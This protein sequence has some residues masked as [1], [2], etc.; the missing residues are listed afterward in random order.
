MKKTL[1]MWAFVLLSISTVFAQSKQITGTV[2]SS[3]DGSGLPGVNITIV[4]TSQGA[5]TDID[6]KYQLN[7][8]AGQVLQFSFVGFETQSVTVGNQSTINVTLKVDASE[9]A[10]VVVTGAYGL[11]QTARSTV[12]NTQVVDQKTLNVIRQ[13]DINNALAGKVSGIQ[14]R[15]QSSAALGRNT[16]V[17]L[18]GV[19]GFGVGTGALYVV[20]GTILPNPGNLNLDDIESVT[21][22]QGAA[23]AAQFGSQGANGAIVITLKKGSREKGIGL[24]VN[25][26][27]MAEKAYILPNY[28]NAYAGGSFGDLVQF[29][30]KAG[31]PEEW[32]ALDG[33]Y[34]HDYSDDSSWGPRMVGQEYIPWYSWYPGHKY[35]G[36]TA[37]LLPQPD[38]AREFFNTGVTYNNTFTVSAGDE[39]YDLKLSYGNQN[40]TGVIPSTSLDKH[41]LN[42]R[43]SYSLTDKLE[44]SADINYVSQIQKGEIDDG[45]ANNS[46][47]SFSQ[48]FHRNV[49]MGIMKELAGVKDPDGLTY[50]TW[51]H[52]NPD[53][54]NPSNPKAFYAANYWYNFYTYFN[55][56]IRKS[57]ADRLYGNLAATYKVNDA[58]SLRATY[59]KN[60]VI[61]SNDTRITTDLEESGL[62]TGVRGFYGYGQSNSNRT[63]IEFLASY[64]KQIGDFSIN[65]SAGTDFFTWEFTS[66]GANTNQG[67][68]VANL[69][70]IT[71][72]VDPAT[73]S[74]NR[75]LEKYR[76]VIGRG[77]FGW[78]DLLYADVTLRNDWYST[79]PQTNN[80]VLSKS[81]GGSFVFY[82]LLKDKISW[83]SNGK[84]RASWGEIPKALGTSN[85][86]FG[87]YRFPGAAYSVGN[88]KWG[89]YFTMATA[90]TLVDPNIQGSTVTQFEYGIDAQFLNDRIG[91]SL[92]LWDGSEKN[93]PYSL[94]VNGASGYTSLLTNIGLIE[95]RGI[96]LQVNGRPILTPNLSWRITGTYSKLTKNDIIELSKEFGI[97]QTSGVQ[98]VWGTTM[99]YLVH[100]E[101]KRWGQIYGNGIKRIN[102]VPVLNSDG[103]YVNQPDV[104]FGSV[105]P[106]FTGGLQNQFVI[107]K[108]FTLNVNID[109]QVGG[110]FVS[111]SNQWGSF[112]G[113]TARTA[114]IN[115][116]GNPIR[117][118]VADGGGVHVKGVN[119]DGEP[120][121]YYVEAQDYFHNNYYNKTFDDYIYDLTFV[122]LREIS[123][124]YNI[125]VERFGLGKYFQ[126]ANLS[127]VGR[128][129]LLIYATTPDFDPSEVS[130]V[131]GESGQFPGTRGLGFNL[132][133]G[134]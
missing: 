112:S 77:S 21:V 116:K 130:A 78:K 107:F 70:S 82:E 52:A 124:G 30:Y 36:T 85:E 14:V 44:V 105:L 54:Y 132:T 18:R 76:A 63:N 74:N 13:T 94:S 23:A 97:T 88:F 9:L 90:N 69:F 64:N 11:T 129:P 53:A 113:L 34:Y 45:Y 25:T 47:G 8:E 110:K 61:A 108:D 111:L 48:W 33:K 55:D 19:T 102:G 57:Q 131:V 93:F 56:N 103:S 99:P 71:N 43:T 126:N 42:V 133:L 81:F 31:M 72:S 89:P 120:V 119:E 134:F 117:D 32:K 75:I 29:K 62:Q 22:L 122:K 37:K 12:T 87:A 98:G 65:A 46:T 15:S 67:L 16:E 66:S 127:I 1:L 91:L 28:Q 101:G 118:A 79:L 40:V 109:F 39:K 86:T 58:L 73:I 10:E 26:G 128:N 100:T 96:D 3:E 106:D 20:N 115:D 59:R 104:Y 35:S 60:Q 5:A 83:L 84:L 92:T 114:T 123:F 125:P 50:I 80:S 51:N 4:G 95:K 49:D 121:D 2:K 24:T 41:L 68:S 27:I 7:V 38:N 17:R 6:G